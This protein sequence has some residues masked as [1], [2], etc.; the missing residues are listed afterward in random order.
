MTETTTEPHVFI[1]LTTIDSRIHA[2]DRTIESLLAQS[3]RNLSVILHL[4][5]EPYLLDQGI[6][7]APEALKAIMRRD[8]RFSIR[9]VPN[10]GPYRKLLPLLAWLG[11][12]SALV[13]TVD[14]DT[15]YPE[16]WLEELVRLHERY[17]CVIAYRAHRM[18][19]TK[20]K[21]A[22]YAQW[23]NSTISRNPDLLLLPTG[24]DGI[25]YDS[26]YFPS[27][28]L[29]YQAARQVAPTADDIWFRWHVAMSNIPVYA[30]S[31]DYRKDTFDSTDERPVSLFH[32]FNKGGGNDAIID[33]IDTWARENARFDI[34]ASSADGG[35]YRTSA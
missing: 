19:A 35:Y 3:H 10:M 26:A 1:S 25:L 29:D 5:H 9:W 7:E 24:K 18:L 32:M 31:T 15:L 23:M 6:A 16:T 22:P 14:D 11:S 30:V 27:S 13:A 28:V 2:I 33:R 4:S 17:R 20:G 8:P 34:V 21:L 12:R